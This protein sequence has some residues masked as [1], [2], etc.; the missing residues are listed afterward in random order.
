MTWHGG[1]YLK[2]LNQCGA[3]SWLFL[4][5]QPEI[6]RSSTI[7]GLK[8]SFWVSWYLNQQLIVSNLQNQR[9]WQTDRE[10]T[11][12]RVLRVKNTKWLDWRTCHLQFF[13]SSP[14]DLVVHYFPTIPATNDQ[15]YWLT[16]QSHHNATNHVSFY[17]SDSRK[18]FITL[19]KHI[20]KLYHLCQQLI[21]LNMPMKSK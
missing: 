20:I 3:D 9:A 2:S 13:L 17:T 1:H 11:I 10:T 6:Q 21:D 16:E 7:K 18:P 12:T 14:L 5:N 8:L 19:N 15:E 4:K